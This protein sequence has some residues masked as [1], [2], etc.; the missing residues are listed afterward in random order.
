MADAL[1]RTP[2]LLS[3]A[4]VRKLALGLVI[5]AVAY[6]ALLLYADAPALLEKSREI[7]AL[8]TRDLVLWD[9]EL[10][11]KFTYMP[12]LRGGTLQLSVATHDGRPLPGWIVRD[13]VRA[14]F[15]QGERVR[16]LRK[17]FASPVNPNTR[18][19]MLSVQPL[20]EECFKEED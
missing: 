6:G 17:E 19:F 15:S 13:I 12:Q 5:G 10:R 16:E 2:P 11:I 7:S 14:F 20:P 8:Y 3:P 1:S 18:Q 4:L 9:W